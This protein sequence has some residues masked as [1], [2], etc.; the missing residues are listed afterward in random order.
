MTRSA[1]RVTSERG[2]FLLGI[3]FLFIVVIKC[4]VR[5]E[6]F[7]L[8]GLC[9]FLFKFIFSVFFL[10][11]LN[12]GCIFT[13]VSYAYDCFR[14]FARTMFF[15]CFFVLIVMCGMVNSMYCFFL[16]K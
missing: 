5:M 7:G 13:S 4:L 2:K 1:R 9:L 12:I 10:Y 15:M 11:C 6:N 8:S 16:V 3:L 14:R